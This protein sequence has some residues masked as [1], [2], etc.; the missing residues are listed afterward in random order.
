MPQQ[1]D[2]HYS[3]IGLVRV[4]DSQDGSSVGGLVSAFA[5]A[6]YEQGLGTFDN[7][8]NKAMARFA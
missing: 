1:T 7:R 2:T 3:D 5:N 8:V 6:E 4:K